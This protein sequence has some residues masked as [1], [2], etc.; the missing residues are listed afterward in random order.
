MEQSFHYP[1]SG[2]THLGNHA[3]DAAAGGD[4]D[5]QECLSVVDE[6]AVSP[7]Q[8]VLRPGEGQGGRIIHCR[9]PAVINFPEF[10]QRLP[11]DREQAAALPVFRQGPAESQDAGVEGIACLQKRVAC[12]I[13]LLRP[14]HFA[15][16]DTFPEERLRRSRGADM[17][18]GLPPVGDL[19][20]N[21][22]GHAVF[23]GEHGDI[24]HVC[25]PFSK[26]IPHHRP[27]GKEFPC[28]FLRRTAGILCRFQ[29]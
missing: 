12:E 28:A 24:F 7:F 20:Q 16:I 29:F 17:D 13:Y 15:E 25:A 10:F 8:Q 14:G 3:V 27:F 6:I 26:S 23:R 18:V 19:L 21:Q 2:S 1:L 11:L 9:H 4:A 5:A 22:A